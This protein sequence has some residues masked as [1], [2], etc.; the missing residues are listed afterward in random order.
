MGAR[1]LKARY[2]IAEGSGRY[3]MRLW[4]LMTFEIWRRLVVEGGVRG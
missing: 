2:D 1:L 4:M 3:G